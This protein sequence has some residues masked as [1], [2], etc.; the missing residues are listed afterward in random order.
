MKRSLVLIPIL[1]AAMFFSACDDT[2]DNPI[3]TEKGTIFLVSV[4]PGAQ[5]W[6]NGV[7]QSKV[8]P[9]SLSNQNVGSYTITL[10]LSGYADTAFTVTVTANQITAKTI[11]LRS[12]EDIAS[13]G[14][15]RIYE[16]VGT[17][18]SQPSGLDLSTG[19][20][21]G[22]TGA[23]K[24]N[25]DLYYAT[26]GT[27][28]QSYL[29]QSAD[30]STQMTRVTK[31]RVGTGATLTDGVDS[32]LQ[33]SGSWTNFVTDRQ[34]NYFFLYDNDGHYSKAKITS[35]GGGTPGSPA[36]VEITYYYNRTADDVRF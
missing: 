1:L 30:L 5:I 18:S 32:W 36:W 25:V 10:K 15:I 31:F 13:F 26:N 21:Y 11:V 12:N 14:P 6:L 9:D 35:F 7:N 4:P 24:G 20:A 3:V 17:T 34:A 16:T 2:T 19:G 27:G 33:S 8:T 29:V 23:D 28:G 22:I